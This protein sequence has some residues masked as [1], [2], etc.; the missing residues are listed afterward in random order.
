[1]VFGIGWSQIGNTVAGSAGGGGLFGIGAGI[2]GHM[3]SKESRKNREFQMIMDSTKY[4]RTMA[5]MERAG[6][7][8]M[9]A[10]QQGVG[11][12]PGGAMAQ[13]PPMEFG[14]GMLESIR[15]KKE[16]KQADAVTAKMWEEAELANA[17]GVTEGYTQRLAESAREL[18]VKTARLRDAEFV[19]A[20]L[21]AD[22]W[23]EAAGVYNSAKQKWQE[24]GKIRKFYRDWNFG[25]PRGLEPKK[26]PN[27]E[28]GRKS[29]GLSV[30]PNR[31]RGDRMTT[32]DHWENQR[33]R[34]RK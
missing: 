19:K 20:G 2:S 21:Q 18:N 28:A 22:A 6:L 5:D 1:M 33:K 3:S 16:V 12:T 7:N 17:K 8:P 11:G 26:K 13:F 34:R 4:A 10:Y 24:G 30:N 31:D 14:K 32:E 25:D 15:V 9:L 23:G 29:K 27:W